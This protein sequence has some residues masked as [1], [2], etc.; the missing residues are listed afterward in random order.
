M[1]YQS[2]QIN[3]DLNVKVKG[4]PNR[5][6]NEIANLFNQSD[7]VSSERKEKSII[8]KVIKGENKYEMELSYDYPFI[9][10]KNIIYNGIIYKQILSNCPKKITNILKTKYYI[11]CLCCETIT[12][13]KWVP[14]MN[15][16]HIINEIDKFL[17]I[18]KEIKIILLCD[19]I[20]DK[21]NCCFA[22]FEKY[23]F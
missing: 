6:N 1:N 18:K 22:E 19:E 23:L 10:P 20:R 11:N 3:T 17:K 7:F 12:C 2:I 4:I 13:S 5:I 9:P 15:T 8:I 16:S 14:G 21:F